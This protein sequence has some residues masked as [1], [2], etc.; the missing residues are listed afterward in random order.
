MII[1]T[2]T[3]TQRVKLKS[4]KAERF[5][6]WHRVFVFFPKEVSAGKLAL[7]QTVERRFRFAYVNIQEKI[8]KDCVEY[9]LPYEQDTTDQYDD[10]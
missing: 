9:R 7:L 10:F 8:V 4:E 1:Y 3:K 6:Q 5:K 2:K